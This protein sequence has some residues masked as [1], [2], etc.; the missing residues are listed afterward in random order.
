MGQDAGLVQGPPGVFHRMHGRQSMNEA[1]FAAK[2]QF[3][4]RVR[5]VTLDMQRCRPL[6]PICHD[7]FD[8]GY[9]PHHGDAWGNCHAHPDS[10]E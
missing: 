3:N 5:A 1:C 8:H 10:G 7:T 9:K 4:F 6:T 2:D